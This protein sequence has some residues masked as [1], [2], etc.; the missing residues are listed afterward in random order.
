MLASLESKGLVTRSRS[1]G[2]DRSGHHRARVIDVTGT[3]RTR[4]EEAEAAVRF[5]DALAFRGAGEEE[6]ALLL[7]RMQEATARLCL[8]APMNAE[9]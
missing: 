3:G 8:I 5:L 1:S 9:F 6:R 2:S 7:A 4:L